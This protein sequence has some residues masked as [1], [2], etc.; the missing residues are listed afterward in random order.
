MDRFGRCGQKTIYTGRLANGYDDRRCQQRRRARTRFP[1]VTPGC[2]T[3]G[4]AMTAVRSPYNGHLAFRCLANI[5][6]RRSRG[7]GH[8]VVVAVSGQPIAREARYL[9]QRRR[10]A[11]L[12]NMHSR[13]DYV[14]GGRWW[15]NQ[16]TQGAAF[17]PTAGRSSAAVPGRPERGDG[18]PD[19]NVL[20]GS[21]W[22]G[23]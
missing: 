23:V 16:F 14:V 21:P 13:G 9:V 20:L 8:D 15:R 12:S 10:D 17:Q 18:V 6:A 7:R 11:V 22:V 19:D 1:S 2:S 5:T 4:L 3:P